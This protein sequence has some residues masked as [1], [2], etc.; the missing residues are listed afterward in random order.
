MHA[1]RDHLVKVV[2]PA[3][4]ERLAPYQIDLYDIDLRWGITQRE[5]NVG[6]ALGCCLRLI[7]DCRPFFVGLLGQRYGEQ[8][9]KIPTTLI[10]EKKWLMQQSHASFTE[11]EIRHAVFEVDRARV[12]AYFYF[13]NP[14]ALHAVPAD[15]RAV[16]YEENDLARADALAELK[17]AIISTGLPVLKDYPAAWNPRLLDEINASS[18]ESVAKFLRFRQPS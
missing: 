6:L 18:A 15:V 14:A 16:V 7:D 10:A 11:L 9:N 5:S 2:F 4:R 8:P 12:K 17:A 1:E 3:L 13:R